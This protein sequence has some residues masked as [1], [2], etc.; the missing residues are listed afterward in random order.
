MVIINLFL[1][2]LKITLEQKNQREKVSQCSWKFIFIFSS[3]MKDHQE[4]LMH[5]DLL[6]PY[7]LIFQQLKR[8]IVKAKFWKI[9][10]FNLTIDPSFNKH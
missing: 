5:Q 3:I 4:Y 6:I 7:K 8:I 2:T 1:K 10:F 9:T